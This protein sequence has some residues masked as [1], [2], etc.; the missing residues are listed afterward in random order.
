MVQ[1]LI[2]MIDAGMSTIQYRFSRWAFRRNEFSQERRSTIERL[3][4][5]LSPFHYWPA[6][7]KTEAIS[8]LPDFRFIDCNYSALMEKAVNLRVLRVLRTRNT[9]KFAVLHDTAEQLHLNNIDH[10]VCSTR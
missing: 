5:R 3:E 1:A 10:H 9:L 2:L 8:A 7:F 4:S 6:H